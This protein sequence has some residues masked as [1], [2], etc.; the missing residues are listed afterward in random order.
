MSYMLKMIQYNLLLAFA[1]IDYYFFVRVM[2]LKIN[3]ADMPINN[4]LIWQ[5]E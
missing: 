1:V 4:L 2:Q 5:L 3:E